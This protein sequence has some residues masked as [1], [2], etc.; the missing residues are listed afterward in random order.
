MA[1]GEETFMNTQVG[2]LDTSSSII[3]SPRKLEND[4]IVKAQHVIDQC[5]KGNG[6]VESRSTMWE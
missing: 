3:Q 1:R 2:D 4:V 5:K 6:V